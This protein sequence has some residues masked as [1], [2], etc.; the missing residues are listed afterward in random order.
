M[1]NV[2][3]SVPVMEANRF[4]RDMRDLLEA[5]FELVNLFEKESE[6]KKHHRAYLHVR[7]QMEEVVKESG[8]R[9][10]QI[11]ADVAAAL[12]GVKTAPSMGEYN[13]NGMNE[14]KDS[15]CGECIC[16]DCKIPCW[17]CPQKPSCPNQDCDEDNFPFAEADAP[18]ATGHVFSDDEIVVMDKAVFDLMVDDILTLAELMEMTTEMRC[19]DLAL[20]DKYARYIPQFAAFEHNRLDVYKDAHFEAEEV[21]NRWDDATF[22][23]FHV[24]TVDMDQ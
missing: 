8:P 23:E 1:E 20:I 17:E 22:D 10:A 11:A 19:E 6:L 3:V 16:F 24:M 15:P 13:D 12:H 14:R 7:E 21:M 9:V 5:H 2:T 18:S 4:L